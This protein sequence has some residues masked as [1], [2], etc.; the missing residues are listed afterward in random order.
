M[1]DSFLRPTF[2]IIA[3]NSFDLPYA[4]RLR[5]FAFWST[6][7][8]NGVFGLGALA[9]L[10][11]MLVPPSVGASSD[12]PNWWISLII[13][14]VVV[15]CGFSLWGFYKPRT[16][17]YP[18][19]IEK[20][21]VFGALAIL[22]RS[23]IKG[24]GPNV[25]SRNGSYFEIMPVSPTDPT[26]RL[27]ASSRKDSVVAAWLQ[28]APDPTAEKLA[29]DRAEV[30]SD[31]RFGATETERSINL[32]RAKT[33]ATTF[34]VVFVAAAYAIF[35]FHDLY[36]LALAMVV[37]AP[38]I[39]WGLVRWSNELIVWFGTSR[40]KPQV[41]LGAV[42]PTLALGFG[43]L[44]HNALYAIWPL[45]GVAAALGLIVAALIYFIQGQA[46]EARAPAIF[47]GAASAAALLGIVAVSD[48]TLDTAKPSIY[49]LRVLDEHVSH[50]K[51]NSY[52]LTLPA[53]PRRQ[54]GDVEVDYDTYHA[55][56]TGDLVCITDHPG[57]LGLPWFAVAICP[58]QSPRS[59]ATP[60]PPTRDP[61]DNLYPE[62]ATR[63]GVEGSA[64]VE[65]GVAPDLTATHCQVIS[66]TPPGYGFGDAAL[67]RMKGFKI[68]VRPANGVF[69]STVRF[70]LA[71]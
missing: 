3:P 67:A 5:G 62:R 42:A 44:F 12:K 69:R 32:G 11:F 50:G 71:N 7:I 43:A 33:I 15:Y 60:V 48:Q 41:G 52:Y 51:S 2:P 66:E 70:Q 65:C 46:P 31:A 21:G 9:A 36:P 40:A 38:I 13:L 54:G 59:A 4:V 30:L 61:S 23:R 49:R 20:R 58:G 39:A 27:S 34:T 63:L 26:I 57:A 17:L 68:S 24:V 45:A 1:A 53:W 22:D 10:V 8:G 29:A 18:D 47:A 28:G 55:V 19:R 56:N 64:K 16:I 6:L 25:Y 37:T 35:I 14:A